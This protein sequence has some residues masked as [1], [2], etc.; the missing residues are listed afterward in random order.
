[1]TVSLCKH[2]FPIQP[3]HGTL[4]NPGNCARCGAT[5]ADVQA[6]LDRQENALRLGT[7]HHGPCTWCHQPRI[8]FRYVREQQPWESEEPAV[9]WLCTRDWSRARQNEETHGFIDFNDLFDHGTDEQLAA[10]LRGAL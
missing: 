9:V 4:T 6:E 2:S 5:W 1:M 3:P 10:G 8:V 7:A